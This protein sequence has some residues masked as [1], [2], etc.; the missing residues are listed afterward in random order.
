M[1]PSVMTDSGASSRMSPA[2]ALL[3]SSRTWSP[4]PKRDTR[5]DEAPEY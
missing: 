3:G 4:A 1:T 5:T 2:T